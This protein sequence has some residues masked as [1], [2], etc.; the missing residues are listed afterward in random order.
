MRILV[1]RLSDAPTDFRFEADSSWWRTHMRPGPGM[2]DGL[3][4]PLQ[5][6]VRAHTMGEDLYFEGQLEGDLALECSRCLARY[7][8]PLHEPFRLV[9]E[10]SGVRVPADPE[11][12]RALER[13]GMCLGEDVE[14]GWYRGSEIELAPF[15]HEVVATAFPV[16]PVCR[17]AC[18]GLCP[19][20]GGDR[21]LKDCSCPEIKQSSPFA[22]L[23]KLRVG[24]TEGEG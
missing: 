20:C 2:P 3:D 14:T 6:G 13:D 1:D 24:R 12:A 16:Q 8:H 5:V 15:F 22:V 23:E 21:N 7:R 4:E 9:L 18:A 19:R 10:P 11:G 17:E